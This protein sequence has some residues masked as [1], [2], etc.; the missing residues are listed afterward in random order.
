MW[1]AALTREFPFASIA[2]IP[3]SQMSSM[4]GDGTAAGN[5]AAAIECISKTFWRALRIW[6]AFYWRKAILFA[7]FVAALLFATDSLYARGA[8]SFW[9]YRYLTEFG[10]YVINYAAALPVLHFILKKKFRNF[11]L[12]LTPLLDADA[13][14][15]LPPTVARTLRIWWTYTWRTFAYCI[16]IYFVVNLPLGLLVGTLGTIFPRLNDVFAYSAGL[17]IEGVAGFFVI[18]S[19][20]L[21]EE[22]GKFRVCLLHKKCGDLS[23]AAAASPRI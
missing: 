5:R 17:A 3:M 10:P 9:L 13:G 16:G 7:I 19:N 23:P 20:I 4:L 2:T 11:R 8:I 22:F 18:Y 21:E 14:A 15:V 1:Q 12:A 6:W